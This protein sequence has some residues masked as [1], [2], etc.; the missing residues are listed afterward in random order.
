MRIVFIFLLL[1]ASLF[2]KEIHSSI[3]L[4]DDINSSKIIKQN[5]FLWRATKDN[6]KIYLFGTIHIPHPLVYY[7]MPRVRKV[8]DESDVVYTELEFNFA[9]ELSALK[10][11]LLDKNSSLKQILPPKLY[12]ESQRYLKSINPILD[13]KSFNR[14]KVWAFDMTLQ[15]LKYQMKYSHIKPLDKQIY[16]YA[17]EKHKEVGGIETMQEQIS[18]FKNLS[19]KEQIAILRDDLKDINSNILEKMATAYIKG[20]GDRVLALAKAQIAKS[21]LPK[22]VIK[23]HLNRLLFD[24]NIRMVDRIDEKVS[25]NLSKKYLFAFGAMHFLGDKSV[26]YYLEKKGYKIER[27]KGDF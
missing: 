12:E 9:T 14:F 27:V 15:M 10:Y 24:R 20:D 18:V 8:I 25:K 5:L 4:K 16:S 19:Q 23:M 3:I 11:M 7:T 26:L 6:S 17:K 21:S 1:I 13:M 22:D 2:G